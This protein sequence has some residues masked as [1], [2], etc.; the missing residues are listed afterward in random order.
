MTHQ[1]AIEELHMIAAAYSHDE[2]ERE[3][4]S[5]GVQALEEQE[6]RVGKWK[7]LTYLLFAAEIAG[8]CL[9]GG[10]AAGLG[11]MFVFGM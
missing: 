10:V 6:S 9:V 2:K 5:M 11:V 4:L 8:F 3:A 1:K 7:I